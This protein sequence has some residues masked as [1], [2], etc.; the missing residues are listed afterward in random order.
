MNGMRRKIAGKTPAEI[1]EM[2][3]EAMKEPVTQDDFFQAS[4]RGLGCGGVGVAPLGWGGS[5]PGRTGCAL[6]GPPNGPRSMGAVVHVSNGR[7]RLPAS[8]IDQPRPS[9]T[10]HP[11]THP[12]TPHHT[13]PPAPPTRAQAIAKINPSVGEKDLQRHEAWLK[14]YGSV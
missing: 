9:P 7:P 6:E 14:E 4:S 2:S 8:L 5:A 1:R 12:P 11:P 13:C 3:R 10:S